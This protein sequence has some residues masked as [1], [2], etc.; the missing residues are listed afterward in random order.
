M[1]FHQC[2]SILISQVNLFD[3]YLSPITIDLAANRV[4]K[5]IKLPVRG[6]AMAGGLRLLPPILDF[7]DILTN[8]YADQLIMA[9]NTNSILPVNYKVRQNF[10][11]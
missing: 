7:G 11:S 2:G 9:T 4:P 1:W 6:K 10:L 8:S 3:C 5:K